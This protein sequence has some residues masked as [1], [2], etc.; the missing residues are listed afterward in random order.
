DAVLQ[1]SLKGKTHRDGGGAKHSGDGRRIDAKMQGNLKDQ[2]GIQDHPDTG[3][4]ELSCLSGGSRA[5]KSL[6]DQLPD[7]TDHAGADQKCD[8]A[9]NNTHQQ[10]DQGLGSSL[11]KLLSDRQ[12][13]G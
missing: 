11:Q 10:I 7:Q 8:N 1:A 9:E 2:K 3:I 5:H 4:D 13:F 12:F 6:S